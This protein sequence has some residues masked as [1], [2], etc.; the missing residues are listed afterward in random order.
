M[1][2]KKDEYILECPYCSGPVNTNLQWLLA[3]SRVCCMSCNKSFEVT[4][5]ITDHDEIPDGFMD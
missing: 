2:D 3:N 1:N 4:A 5:K